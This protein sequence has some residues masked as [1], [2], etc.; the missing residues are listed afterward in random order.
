MRR[1]SLNDDWSVRPKVHRFAEF[2][3]ES[4]EWTR[5]TLPHDAMIGGERTPMAG[6]QTGYFPG[7]IWEYRRTLEGSREPTGGRAR[8]RG[9]L[10]RG[11][12]VRERHPRR[13]PTVRLLEILGADRRAPAATREE[14]ELRVKVRADEDSRWYSGAGIYRNVQLLSRGRCTSL[15]TVCR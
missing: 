14:N 12:G 2:M 5:V 7:G 9:R 6:P 11:G 8:V 1:I 10:P 13:P 3:G 15:S 4:T